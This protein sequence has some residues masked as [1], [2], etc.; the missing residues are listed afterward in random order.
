[1]GRV[2]LQIKRIENN[3]N[4]Q[5]TFSKRRNG[6]IKKAYEL[7]VLCDIDIALIMFSPSGRLSHFSGKK[8]IE[9]VLTRFINLPDHDRGRAIH[10]REYV[11]RT[12]KKLKCE[13]DVAAQLANPGAVNAQVEELQ[14]EINRYQQQLQL[15]EERLRIFEPDPLKFASM[16][17]SETCEKFLVEALT[18]VSHRKKYLLTNHLSSYDPSSISVYLDSQEGLTSFENEVA[19]WLPDQNTPNTGQIFVGS[20]PLIHLRDQQSSLYDPL[21]HPE[22]I[23]VDPTMGECHISNSSDRN[24]SDWQPAFTSAELL[25]AL[26]TPGSF[27]LVQQELIGHEIPSIIPGDQMSTPTTNCS[28]LPSKFEENAAWHS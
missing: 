1:M 11:I 2:K 17:E 24:L 25:S 8:R 9:D 15:A 5:V 27:P 28:Q 3:T 13:S 4:R 6:L 7:S 19:S 26:I 12:L 21:S 10:N 20:D 22:G 16:E 23:Q 14:H 18:R